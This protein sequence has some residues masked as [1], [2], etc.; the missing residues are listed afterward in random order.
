MINA[1]TALLLG[2]RLIK[3]MMTNKLISNIIRMG[4]YSIAEINKFLIV[5]IIG[6]IVYTDAILSIRQSLYEDPESE[7][8]PM[9]D[10]SALN[11]D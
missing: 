5:L 8:E 11:S 2:L 10:M 6:V 3:V 1:F 4:S 9:V 7:M